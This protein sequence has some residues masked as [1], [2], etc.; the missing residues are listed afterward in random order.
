MFMTIA[1]EIGSRKSGNL[2]Q[3]QKRGRVIADEEKYVVYKFMDGSEILFNKTSTGKVKS[4]SY[5]IYC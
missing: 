4:R 1:E 2:S 5:T 3:A